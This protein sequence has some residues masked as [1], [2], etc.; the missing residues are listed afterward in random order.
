MNPLPTAADFPVLVAKARDLVKKIH[1][2]SHWCCDRAVCKH[3]EESID[4]AITILTNEKVPFGFIHVGTFALW[5][6]SGEP[7]YI[8]K[9]LPLYAACIA[10][11]PIN[12]P[13]EPVTYDLA[14]RIHD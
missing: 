8:H 3:T 4:T 14:L 9:T 10:S 12:V 7:G 5:V 11:T 1:P 13:L 2:K 6:A